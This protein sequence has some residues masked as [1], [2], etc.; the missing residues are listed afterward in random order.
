VNRRDAE[1][2][3]QSQVQ[4]ERAEHIF[5]QEPPLG[6]ISLDEISRAAKSGVCLF[7][8]CVYNDGSCAYP[9]LA[10]HIS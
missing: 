9:K 3:L 1:E 7:C 5:N 2:E 6:L 4:R 10:D 8:K